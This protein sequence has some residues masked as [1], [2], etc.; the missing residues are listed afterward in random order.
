MW[1]DKGTNRMKQTSSNA[2][3]LEK[4]SLLKTEERNA[5]L[6]FADL[7]RE[8]FGFL[9]KELIL[10]GSKARGESDQ[11]SDIDILVVLTN[12]SWEIKKSISELAAEENLKHN[13]L[14]STI[15]YDTATWESPLIKA[16][17]FAKSIREEGIWL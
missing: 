14:I 17:P 12:L 8:R 3:N 6:E 15:R 7:L 5:V 13:V 16:S 2:R 11:E 10:F 4:L 1:Q 9:I